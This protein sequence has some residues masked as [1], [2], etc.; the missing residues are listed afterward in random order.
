MSSKT[1]GGARR[2][3]VNR[4]GLFQIITNIMPETMPPRLKFS[5]SQTN[6]IS[7]YIIYAS[8]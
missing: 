4:N 7:L 5:G 2:N 3:I 6:S 8:S 1:I